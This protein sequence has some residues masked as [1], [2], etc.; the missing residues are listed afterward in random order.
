[1]R[2][3]E[4]EGGQ[5]DLQEATWCCQLGFAFRCLTPGP[6]NRVST[7]MLCTDCKCVHFSDVRVSVWTY[8]SP[9]K[10]MKCVLTS[11]L[12]LEGLRKAVPERTKW[13][14]EVL[15]AHRVLWEHFTQS[16][17]PWSQFDKY[18][19]HCYQCVYSPYWKNFP[20]TTQEWTAVN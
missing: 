11:R 15:Q 19:G 20:M 16:W 4:D 13:R 17:G 6:L 10:G 7:A 5:S 9:A 18:I 8:S 1:M 2:E 3:A 14:L 12:K